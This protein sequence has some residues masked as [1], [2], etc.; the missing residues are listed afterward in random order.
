MDEGKATR[1]QGAPLAGVAAM[2]ALVVVGLSMTSLADPAS[3]LAAP[4]PPQF[5]APDSENALKA[6]EQTT[7]TIFL[8]FVSRPE[9]ITPALWTGEYYA[10]PDLEGTPAYTTTERRVDYD[11]GQD[12]PDGL[13]DDFFSI[14]WT[15]YWH[16]EAG[17]YTTLLYADEGMRLWLDDQQLIDAWQPGLGSHQATFTVETAGLHRLKLEY[18]E[19]QGD[20]AISLHWRRTD[21]YPLWHGDYYSEPW[22]EDGWVY[23][24]TDDSIQFD[25]GLGCPVG[26]P[27]D[28]FSIAWEATPV[29]EPGLY[30]IYLYADEGYQ[31]FFD[32]NLVKE[33]GWDDGQPGGGED[34]FYQVTF[35]NTAYHQIN[36]NFHDRGGPA[37]ARLWVEYLEHPDWTAQ[38]YENMNLEGTPTL[39][40][41][42]ETVFYDWGFE[43]PR[44]ALPSD[45]FSIRWSG[46]RYFHSGCYRFGLFADD[47]VRLWVDGEKLVDQWH[48]G[49]SE[50]H[51]LVTYLAAGYHTVVIEYYENT[52]EAEI[53]FWWE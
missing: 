4:E 15:G 36:Y 42:E 21:L 16:F 2:L 8:P 26:L 20:A 6:T 19:N 5:A 47:G 23:A 52:G 50:Y 48:D 33:G 51:S 18:F 30:R 32:E 9:G 22:V 34:D 24:Q 39:T 3:S 41:S 29:F 1:G 40:K 25:W 17:E 46:Q 44:P 27:C 11:W 7:T 35:A 53:R 49:R 13:P 43:S 14:R 10:N 37:E 38:Y 31:L 12:A 28:S 45:H